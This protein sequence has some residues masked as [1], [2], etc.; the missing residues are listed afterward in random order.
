[1]ILSAPDRLDIDRR[2]DDLP[3]VR[4]QEV[5]FTVSPGDRTPLHLNPFKNGSSDKA[6][7]LD[8]G[9]QRAALDS[10]T[11]HAWRPVA[12]DKARRSSHDQRSG[13]HWLPE[14]ERQRLSEPLIS[15]ENTSS[16]HTFR[17]SAAAHLDGYVRCAGCCGFARR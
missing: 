16:A 15:L 7:R 8:N 17:W 4:D 1:V 2:L 14:G 11:S 10:L 13:L 9:P 6:W 12:H 3:V 5:S